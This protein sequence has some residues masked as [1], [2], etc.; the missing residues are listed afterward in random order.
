MTTLQYPSCAHAAISFAFS[1]RSIT[2]CRIFWRISSGLKSSAFEDP[3][4]P[5]VPFFIDR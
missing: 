5:T 3:A 2:L 4:A 1:S